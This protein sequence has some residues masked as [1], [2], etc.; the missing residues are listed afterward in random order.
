MTLV[1]ILDSLRE[2][3]YLDRIDLARTERRDWYP[4]GLLM[5]ALGAVNAF[6]TLYAYVSGISTLLLPLHLFYLFFWSIPGFSLILVSKRTR[7]PGDP[8]Y[9]WKNFLGERWE[10]QYIH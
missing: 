1:Y 7:Y 3:L 6:V 8:G 9:N 10:P 2:E 4:A 5:L